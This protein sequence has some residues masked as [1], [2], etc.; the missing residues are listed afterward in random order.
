[1]EEME[2]VALTAGYLTRAMTEYLL[3]IIIYDLLSCC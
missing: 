3:C 2:L 1:M